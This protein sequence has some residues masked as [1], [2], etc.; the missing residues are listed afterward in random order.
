[1]PDLRLTTT[2]LER[3]ARALLLSLMLPA[4]LALQ[5]QSVRYW[6]G[7]T[8]AWAD[9]AHWAH[10]PGGPGGAGVPGIHDRAV[11]AGGPF[12]VDLPGTTTCGGLFINGSSGTITVQGTG[13][14]LDIHGDWELAGSTFWPASNPITLIQDGE[15]QVR[16]RGIPIGG[17]V[18]VADGRWT[19]HSDLVLAE[20][21]D[22]RLRGGT[23]STGNAMLRASRLRTEGARRKTLEAGT[24]VIM[25]EE[26]LAPGDW[27]EVVKEDGSYLVVD[28]NM[29][30]WGPEVE[31]MR[32]I[33][34][35]GTGPGQTMFTIDA[36]L[37]SNYNGY[38]VSCNGVCDGIVEVTITGGSGNFRANWVG[39]PQNSLVWNNVCTG[40]RIVVVTDLTQN[41]S[42]ATT[43]QVTD[44]ALLTVIFYGE[45]P[46]SCAGVCDGVSNVF[47]VGGVSDYDYSWNN[48]AG[49]GESFTQ[50]CP[51]LN[52]L[53]VTDQNGCVFDTTFVFNLQPILPGLTLSPASCHGDC[54][55]TATAA[56][57]GGGG[58]YTYEW[59]PGTPVGDGTPAVSGL[60]PGDY[61]LR[62]ADVNGCDTTVLFTITEPDPIEPHPTS[63]DASCSSSCNGNAE[64]APTG[65]AGPFSFAWSP[66]GETTASISGLCAGSYTCLITD[67]ATGCDTLV[68]FLI[69]APPSILPDEVVTDVTCADGCDGT[70][71]TNPAGGAGSGFSFT[72]VP[73]VTG[74]GTNTAT[75]LCPGNY[76]LTIEDVNGCDTTLII[77]VNAPAPL[78]ADTAHTD[79][80]CAGACDG[81]ASVVPSGGTGLLT[82]TWSPGGATTPMVTGLC[83]GTWTA[84]IVDGA[85][86]DT[87]IS[88]IIAEPSPLAATPSQTNVT[89]GG[90][91]N[92]TATVLVT[93]GTANYDYLWT[94]NVAGQ[95]TNTATA[96]CA[97]D[98]EVLIT[99]ANGCTMVQAFTILDAV[100]LDVVVNTIDASCPGVCDGSA[101]VNVSGGQADYDLF[102]DPL[103]GNGQG[104]AFATGLCPQDHSLTVTDELGCDTTLIVTIAAPD[105]II[106]N[107]V[108]T[109]VTCHGDCDGSIVLT[110]TGGNGT[111]SYA[112]TPA[113]AGTG[114]TAANLCAGTYSVTITSGVCDTSLVF[115]VGTPAPL[116]VAL[117]LTHASCAGDCSGTATPTVNGG[118]GAYTF[119]WTPTPSSGQGAPAATDLCAGTYSLTVT[120]AAGC[121]TTLVFEITEPDAIDP[122]L[123]VQAESCLAPCTGAASLNITGGTPGFTIDW[124]PDPINGDGTTTVTDL[125]A[126]INYS[127]RITDIAGCDT[128][129]DFTVDPAEPI[130]GSVTPTAASCTNSCDGSAVASLPGGT[131]GLTLTWSGP[132]TGGQ[133]TTTATGLCP[134]PQSLTITNAE[135]C[136]TTITFTI[137]APPPIEANATVDHVICHGSCEG[138]IALLPSGGNGSYSY[139][140]T[141]ASLGTD[142]TVS[143]LC[144]GVYSVVIT[145]GGCDTTYT[146]TITS[147]PRLDAGLTLAHPT[148]AGD[149]DGTA[150]VSATGGTPDYGYEWIP[151]VNG[152]NTPNASDL[153]PGTYVLIITDF[154]GCDTS[155]VFDIIAPSPIDPGLTILPENCLAPCTGEATLAIT[156]GQGTYTIDWSPDPISGDGTAHV[157]GLCSGITYSVQITDAVGCDTLSTFTVDP[158]VPIAA[159]VT[160]TVVSCPGACDGEAQVTIP[161]GAPGLTLLWSG[162]PTGGQGTTHA[163]GFCPGTYSLTITTPEGC[164]TVI[165]FSIDAPPAIV[166]DATITEPGCNGTCDGGIVLTATGGNGTYTYAWS[167]GGSTSASLSNI[168]AGTYTVL[169]SSGGCTVTESFPLAAPPALVVSSTAQPSHCSLCDGS[170]LVHTSG[171]SGPYTFNWG[172][173]VN[174]TTA[175]STQTGLCAGIYPVQV[176]DANGCSRSIL[177]SVGDSGAEVLTMTDGQ[178][179]CPGSCDGQV[180]VA[181]NCSVPSCTIA[182]TDVNNDPVGSGGNAVSGLCPG[183]YYVQVTNG[184][185]CIAID[186]AVVA[187]A[188]PFAGSIASTPLTC[189]ATCDG[190]AT[191]TLTNPGAAVITWTP[192]PGAGQGTT[193]ATQL[194]ARTYSVFVDLPGSCDTTFTVDITAP[195]PL[196][197]AA[198]IT[199]PSCNGDC[200]GSI[201]VDATGGNGVFS[202]SWSPPPG[203]GQG[204][205][206]AS[207]LCADTYTVL[208]T[209]PAGCDT[210]VTYTVTEPTALTLDLSA[211]DS[212]CAVCDGSAT[213]VT[214]GGTGAVG[215][216]WTDAT[217]TVVGNGAGIPGLCAGTY[218]AT[219]TD[220]SGCSVQA[221]VVVQ[222]ADGEV[223]SVVDDQIDCATACDGEVS[224][225]FTCSTPTCTASWFALD[226]TLL[227]SDTEVLTGL[228][229]GSYIVHVVNGN[230]CLSVDTATVQPVQFID[231]VATIIPATC[232]GGCD[233]SASVSVTGGAGDYHYAWSPGVHPD[234]NAV[235]GLC[236]GSYD[237]LITDATGCDTTVT[238]VVPHPAPIALDI[239]IAHVTCAAACDGTILVQPSGSNGGFTIEWTT[240]PPGG[241][242]SNPATGLCAGEWTAVITDVLG[243]DTTVSL[244]IVEPMPLTVS[245]VTTP[246]TC[247]VCSG[248][249]AAIP[250]GGI[251]GHTYSWSLGAAVVSTDSLVTGLCAGLYTLEVTDANGCSAQVPVAISDADGEVLTT[252]DDLV[253]CPGDCDGAVSVAFTCGTPDCTIA[254]YDGGGVALGATGNVATG[255]CAGL[256]TVEVTNGAGC[257]SFDT[258]F[259]QEPAPIT[260][261]PTSTA[262]HCAGDCNGS[263]VL[264]ASGGTGADYSY[265][266]SPGDPNGDGTNT[267]TDLCAGTWSV[268]ITDEAGCSI[269]EDIELIDPAPVSAI[270]VVDPVSCGGECDGAITITASGGAGDYSYNWSP[271]DPNGDGTN[272]IVDLCAG[273]WSVTIT[274]LLG[275]EVDYSVTLTDPDPLVLDLVTTDNPCSGDCIGTAAV[276]VSGGGGSHQATWLNA[277]GDTLADGVD[278]I[279]SLCAGDY[280]VTITDIN[281]CIRTLPF[282]IDQGLPLDVSLLVQ[283]ESCNGPCDG[284]ATVQDNGSGGLLQFVWSNSPDMP[285]SNTVTGLC[286]GDYSVTVT[287][288]AGCDTTILFTIDPFTPIAVDPSVTNVTCHSACDGAITLNPSGGTSGTAS[289]TYAWTPPP[290]ISQG[291]TIVSGLCPQAYSVL[292][293]DPGG[294]TAQF[295]FTITEPDAIIITL[296]SIEPASCANAS[297]GGMEVTLGGGSGALQPSWTGPGAFTSTEEDLS[298]IGPGDYVLTVTDDNGCTASQSFTVG[299]DNAL[300][301]DA[302]R[303]VSACH[304]P[305]LLLDGSA[306][307]GA[308]AYAWTDGNGRPLGTGVQLLLDGLGA[309]SHTIIL[310]VTAGA[311][312]DTDTVQVQLWA[313]PEADAGPDQSFFTTGRPVLGGDPSGPPGSSFQWSPDS[314]LNDPTLPNPTG[315]LEQTTVF[316]LTVTT[317]EGCTNSD[318]VTIT[319]LPRFIVPSGFTPN[320]DGWNDTWQIAMIHL[321]PDCVVEVFNRWGEPLFRS[322]G[323]KQPW[324]G[325]Y[326][327]GLVPVGTYYYAITLNDPEF[328]EPM[329]GPLTVIR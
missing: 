23:L 276:T 196:Q 118:T 294:C 243:C 186:S 193:Q 306:S 31:A 304:V 227:A 39:G 151:D 33:N 189:S 21:R 323:Y 57:S 41:I 157:T 38:G 138:S 101:I 185:G 36:H 106:A 93:G 204:T 253:S 121:D 53:E 242:A 48:G 143:N 303:D 107:G 260:A 13:G 249:A 30:G 183:T 274:D 187:P 319:I 202:Y 234:T 58:G 191:L 301:A 261:N 37:V 159:T 24:S 246:S 205:A 179:S 293:T 312:M 201:E 86:C 277:A 258:A 219:A 259:V 203:D 103:P 140:W 16:T 280:S 108:V 190:T 164:D 34:V 8:G 262:P 97:G 237:V 62:I 299:T 228:C 29:T 26:P 70:I 111:Y 161:G 98:L 91:C 43:V 162:A 322:V 239:D 311:C 44:P 264:A 99:D 207:L 309:G 72:W 119:L 49:T 94:P 327:G 150:S 146:F 158:Y 292:V 223:L 176:L 148:C 166:V 139:A 212:H 320:G 222:D 180:A 56:A 125:C 120:D 3:R 226:G 273:T 265:D 32:G 305:G 129:V 110:P 63:T 206:T 213:A 104:V 255:L 141:P 211:T 116:D 269:T 61:S 69:A 324:D 200:T 289:S 326:G 112:W 45:V 313:A 168:C 82:V 232:H 172:A 147:P 329:T 64:V 127:V 165:D 131:A 60:C 278:N 284:T 307:L 156:G 18:I 160:P 235:A 130:T 10:T 142:A 285:G 52:T 55:G 236:A 302:G 169:V 199:P 209:D 198:V 241:P 286:A 76:T 291:D 136:D 270:A 263:I 115:T 50:L 173:P 51:G 14:Q 149:C 19:M 271:G 132:P 20:G 317:A 40:N 95:G 188:G 84:L 54:D 74:Q 133:G 218:T 300:T 113:S 192:N 281:G 22:L 328:P 170:I 135:G 109:D 175:D 279:S 6:T 248:T 178:E 181:F 73:N 134:G 100:P 267:V 102:W 124:A 123:S 275:C 230:G 7:G 137:D 288:G 126:G 224:V 89:C 9:A 254:W 318:S 287:D 5:A 245:A 12:T 67:L 229:A 251:P 35:C 194:C 295:E 195:A 154:V 163:T 220:A 325:R 114:A 297:D 197:V 117:A 296:D 79:V 240:V 174:T 4:T 83:A 17:D 90:L 266:W 268:T 25:L 210:T 85:G 81:T 233:G 184:D 87:T 257:I 272:T 152:Q 216:V 321:F 1:M 66:G 155:F 177:V 92:G 298:G 75:E 11:I 145:S 65:A 225:V 238:I 315:D 167:P 42:C 250:T 68:E 314:L 88:F 122:G 71:T 15:A 247:G 78:A 221:Q 144:T 153:C 282:A 217:N 252:T 215:I 80:T 47:A 256:Y 28:G 96:L 182:W 214:A 171:G 283:G 59:E 316:V 46:P 244:T 128:L 2:P 208:I 310:Q 308:D 27:A 290:P 105:P 231:V 77:P